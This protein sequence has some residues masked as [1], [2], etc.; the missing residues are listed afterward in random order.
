MSKKLKMKLKL[1]K[2]ETQ[3][4]VQVELEK[5]LVDQVWIQLG[6]DGLS[7]KELIRA[8]MKAYLDETKTKPDRERP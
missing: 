1:P 6:H 3:L 4:N 7:M 8:S 5:S 2:K